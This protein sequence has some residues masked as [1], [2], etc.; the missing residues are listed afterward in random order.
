M[1]AV[2]DA[3]NKKKSSPLVFRHNTRKKLDHPQKS[4]VAA[5]MPVLLTLTEHFVRTF[6]HTKVMCA[7]LHVLDLH[8]LSWETGS[9]DLG[10]CG[11]RQ[12]HGVGCGVPLLGSKHV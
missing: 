1:Q 4:V 9:I 8:E 10:C 6:R 7:M 12:A 11:P 5:D 2:Y 3:A